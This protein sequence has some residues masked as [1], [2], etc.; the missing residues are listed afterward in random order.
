MICPRCNQDDD[1][2]ID[3]RGSDGGHVVRRRR[4][5][6]SCSWRFT[7]YERC[8]LSGRLVVVKKDGSRVPFD[9]DNILRGILAACGKRPVSEA[10]KESVVEHVER[11]VRRDF[12]LEVPSQ[13]IGLR[14]AQFLKDLD[15]ISYIR[16]ASEYRGFEDLTELA[17]E[18]SSLQ[19]Q[20][21]DDPGQQDLFKD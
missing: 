10:D 4:E 3:S 17:T 2:V 7:T 5:C 9:R 20:P 15:D 16:Y 19:S 8:E 12:D 21:K 6:Q 18:V 1:K 13:E 11:L 14:V